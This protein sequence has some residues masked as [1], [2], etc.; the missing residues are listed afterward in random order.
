MS[1]RN[2][3][4]LE[5]EGIRIDLQEIFCTGGDWMNLAQDRIQG[6]TLV[7]TVLNLWVP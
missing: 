5:A 6:R 1:G 3:L 2:L 7:S 4:I